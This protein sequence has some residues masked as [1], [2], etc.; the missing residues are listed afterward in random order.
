M[1]DQ[2]QSPKRLCCGRPFP[3]REI[4]PEAWHRVDPTARETL[5]IKVSRNTLAAG[6]VRLLQLR[7]P[8]AKL[9]RVQAGQYLQ[10]AQADGRRLSYST[11]NPQRDDE[12]KAVLCEI[13]GLTEA[14]SPTDF[15]HPAQQA[16]QKG[17]GSG[18]LIR[19]LVRP[20]VRNTSSI[21]VRWAEQEPVPAGKAVRTLHWASKIEIRSQNCNLS[22]G[23]RSSLGPGKPVPLLRRGWHK[24]ANAWR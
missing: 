4:A 17:S 15:G 6:D 16:A 9:A 21:V 11:V 20:L 8:A 1:R 12:L 10:M 5:T 24:R 7:L 22:N 19:L 23:T 18:L 3:F 2:A 14:L 13:R